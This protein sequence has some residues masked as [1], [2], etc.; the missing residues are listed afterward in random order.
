MRLTL[1]MEMVVDKDVNVKVDEEV[2]VEV[3]WEVFEEKNEM[4]KFLATN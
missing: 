2:N 1:V 3:D 4:S